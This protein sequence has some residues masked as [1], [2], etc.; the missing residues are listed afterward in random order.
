MDVRTLFWDFDQT[1]ACRD[2]MWSPTVHDLL[3]RRGITRITVEELHARFSLPDSFPWHRPELSHAAFFEGVP[4]WDAMTRRFARTLLDMGVP[5]PDASA[6]ALG[7]R[8]EYLNPAKWRLYDDTLPCL[9][10]RRA[11]GTETRSSPTTFRTWASWC[12]P[13]ASTGI[14]KRCMPL[15]TSAGKSPTPASIRP[16]LPEWAYPPAS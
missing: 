9:D 7:V 1:L 13:S 6:V 14:L 11:K 5:E 2:G 4:W 8:A 10:R 15:R 3:L 12:K 16:R